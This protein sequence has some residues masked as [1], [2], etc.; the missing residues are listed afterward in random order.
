MGL[1]DG[2]KK[3]SEDVTSSSGS[4]DDLPPIP[5][6]PF[7]PTTNDKE[8]ADSVDSS[9]NFTSESSTVES[10]LEV[11]ENNSLESTIDFNAENSSLAESS[12][13]DLAKDIEIPM[14]SE[15]D[16]QT[17]AVTETTGNVDDLQFDEL[18]K[19]AEDSQDSPSDEVNDSENISS[20]D[21][22]ENDQE[23]SPVSFS[24][25]LPNFTDLQEDISNERSGDQLAFDPSSSTQ[26]K[27]ES[28]LLKSIFVEREH[29]A[30]ILFSLKRV[31]DD[32][33]KSGPQ[34]RKLNHV[35]MKLA[36]EYSKLSILYEHFN[37]NLMVIEHI[38]SN[39][40]F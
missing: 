7:S 11:P 38:L 36:K 10:G 18:N 15:E 16:S 8:L 34:Q 31:K 6:N 26:I 23:S 17:A 37:E 22:L 32:L 5:E 2:F 33:Q 9:N 14:L 29:Y 28:L 24:D 39:E 4:L 19:E 40:Q 1:L 12:S 20:N 21:E 13:T 27:T 3:K 35:D 25:D 30:N